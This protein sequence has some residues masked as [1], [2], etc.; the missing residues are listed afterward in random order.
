MAA[1]LSRPQ[2]VNELNQEGRLFCVVHIVSPLKKSLV[3]WL[4]SPKYSIHYHVVIVGYRQI[5]NI[6]CTLVVNK[7][8]DHSDVVGAS[9][10]GAAP[11]TS[12]FLT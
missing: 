11:S 1:I 8:V 10:V 2:C 4:L 9:P 3:S 5:S 12:S 6:R 7:I